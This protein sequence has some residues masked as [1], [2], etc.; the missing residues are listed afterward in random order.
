MWKRNQF[1]APKVNYAKISQLPTNFFFGFQSFHSN[2]GVGRISTALKHQ[3]FKKFDEP[4]LGPI[5]FSISNFSNSWITQKWIL[6]TNHRFFHG[7]NPVLETKMLISSEINEEFGD[8]GVI[9]DESQD[10]V[11]PIC[12]GCGATLQSQNELDPGF[13]TKKRLKSPVKKRSVNDFAFLF[14]DELKKAEEINAK[15]EKEPDLIKEFP[16]KTDRKIPLEIDLDLDF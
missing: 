5:S 11:E 9:F 14:Q 16:S 7:H 6:L 15:L 10:L 12:R 13:I 2:L 8:E 3:T 4:N 1:A